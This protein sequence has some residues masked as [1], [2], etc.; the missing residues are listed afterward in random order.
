VRRA[1]QGAGNGPDPAGKVPCKRGTWVHPHLCYINVATTS[2]NFSTAA[3]KTPAR[4]QDRPR[5]ALSLREPTRICNTFCYANVTQ[6]VTPDAQDPLRPSPVATPCVTGAAL[7]SSCV[8][9]APCAM[10]SASPVARGYA[11][12]SASRATPAACVSGSCSAASPALGAHVG[13]TVFSTPASPVALSPP[14]SP[15]PVGASASCAPAA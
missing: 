8:T 4:S 12:W 10:G 2:A 5:P 3:R 11:P 14:Q 15:L 6:T 1:V 9:P 13:R 7:V